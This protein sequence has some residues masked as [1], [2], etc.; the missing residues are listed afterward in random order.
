MISWLAVAAVSASCMAPIPVPP[1]RYAVLHFS[2]PIARAVLPPNAA[3]SGKP[4]AISQDTLLVVVKPKSRVQVVVSLA[5][6]S[7]H[8][9]ELVA[10]PQADGNVEVP[11]TGAPVAPPSAPPSRSPDAAAASA[12]A[13]IVRE[14]HADG[15]E[16]EPV[17][18]LPLLVYDRLTAILEA[19]W[20]SGT[21]R[22]V[23]YRL[24]A[25]KDQASVLDP[26]Q[27][28]RPGVIAASL[29]DETV[30]PGHDGVLYLVYGL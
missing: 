12:L 21:M 29:G 22:V 14:G 30:A 25:A 11:C 5:D 18:N 2:Q 17:S 6:G 8:P 4:Y 13:Q 10:D 19:A 28:Y 3:V 15:F 20:T 1:G 24:V 16:S 23:R 9:L 26:S 7:V 27:F